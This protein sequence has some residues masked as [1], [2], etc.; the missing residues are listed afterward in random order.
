MKASE[1]TRT[2]DHRRKFDEQL[3]SRT[4]LREEG[5]EGICEL[6]ERGK[7]QTL[8]TFDHG[9]AIDTVKSQETVVR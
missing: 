9:A 4:H 8:D 7:K 3:D 1:R 6:R 2:A 5:T